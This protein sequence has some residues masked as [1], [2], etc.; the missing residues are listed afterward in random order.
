VT[1][2]VLTDEYGDEYEA[3]ALPLAYLA[4]DDE[5]DV[6]I[7]AVGGLDRRYPELHRII[8]HPTAV[9]ADNRSPDNPWVIDVEAADG[10]RT[11][12]TFYRLPALP[13]P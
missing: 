1:I 6:V 10:S 12:L 2:E 5:D 13:P 11:L 8:N 7:V 4:Y 9:L 3:E